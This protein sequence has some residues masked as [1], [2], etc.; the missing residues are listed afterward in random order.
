MPQG[1]LSAAVIGNATKSSLNVTAAKVIKA[2][3]GVLGRILVVVAPTTS[4]ALVVNDCSTVA[5]A[6][7]AN[8]V[9]SVPFGSLVAG[10]VIELGFP[11]ST[12]IVIST[13]GGGSPQYSVSYF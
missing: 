11:F 3:N 8:Q 5:A 13:V 2:T 12:G 6:A 1:P 10:Q 9:L 7:T 4:G